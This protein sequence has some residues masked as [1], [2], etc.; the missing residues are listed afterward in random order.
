M[1]LLFPALVIFLMRLADVSLGTLRIGMVVKGKRRWAGA[2]G[3][4][5]SII[6][7]LAARQVLGDLDEPVTMLAYAGGYAAG[8]MFGATI[9]GW[10]AMGSV[11]VRI[12]AP[13]GAVAAHPQLREA[14]FGATV[15]NGQGQDGEVRITFAVVARRRLAEALAIVNRNTPEAFVT[16]EDATMAELSVRPRALALRK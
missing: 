5:E 16:I 9:E 11:L 7:V 2:L 12:V 4:L 1:Q 13:V 8:T 15:V 6:W 3:F 14:G 10:L